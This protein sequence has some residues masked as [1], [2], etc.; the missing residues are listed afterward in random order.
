MQLPG[1]TV[2]LLQRGQP[3]HGAAQ[4][5]AEGLAE[6]AEEEAQ[7]GIQ[8][9][10]GPPQLH[11]PA[12]EALQE[13][14]PGRVLEEEDPLRHLPDLEPQPQARP[15]E[16]Q[17]VGVDGR[18]VSGGE[19][20]DNGEEPPLQPGAQLLLR[21]GGVAVPLDGAEVR[22]PGGQDLAAV[23]AEELGQRL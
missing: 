10:Q 6:P 17:R 7:G 3:L 21:L 4:G 13:P 14:R 8:G 2:A 9:V 20:L 11:G 23:A 5:A 15:A 19:R 22:R 16:R 12:G 1:Q 18:P